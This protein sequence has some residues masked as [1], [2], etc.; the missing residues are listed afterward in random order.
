MLKLS[1]D[2]FL[3]GAGHDCGFEVWQLYVDISSH[4]LIGDAIIVS[5]GLKTYIY[6]IAKQ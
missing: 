3:V 6:D 5:Q 4:S 1:K 2:G